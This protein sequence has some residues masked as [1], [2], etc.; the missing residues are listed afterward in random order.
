[1]IRKV[2]IKNYALIE[3]VSVSFSNGFTVITG[4]TGAGKSILLSAL[5]LALGN[6]LENKNLFDSTKKCIVEIEIDIPE[7]FENWFITNDVDYAA[8][9]IIRRE[10]L[11]SGK[12]RLFINDSPINQGDLRLLMDQLISI[13]SQHEAYTLLQPS[14]QLKIL[15]DFSDTL[16]LATEFKVLVQTYRALV[17]KRDKLAQSQSEEEKKW[18]YLS[19]IREELE[20][21]QV[22]QL[23]ID[24]LEQEQQ[25]LAEVD[26]IRSL[27][28]E[29]QFL[30]S[31]DELGILSQLNKQ[32]RL[33]SEL[34]NKSGQFS[35]LYERIQ[36]CFIE[37]KDI[38]T[39]LERSND[40]IVADPNRLDELN[41][42]LSEVYRLQQKHKLTDFNELHDLYTSLCV[43]LSE[44]QPV[45]D[46]L[47]DI[48]IE[49]LALEQQID[50]K[51]DKLLLLRQ[52]GAKI[53][54]TELENV[55]SEL[56]MPS[57]ELC[58]EFNPSELSLKGKH[59]IDLKFRANKGGSLQP[60]KSAISGGELSRL[61]L[62]ME[63]VR[64]KI[65]AIPAQIFDEIDS[66]VSGNVAD[67]IAQLFCKMGES[68][69][70]IVI[71]HLPQVA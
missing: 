42:T 29:S 8:Q 59:E 17:D 13:H 50:E 52:K 36:S 27:L 16:G 57:A 10:L 41:T 35:T 47:K 68:V 23:D 25:T 6:R 44:Y 31:D 66:G 4:E 33:L 9:S 2:Y 71:S 32:V 40:S 14:E 24:S 70:L 12:S 58:F 7:S 53:L 61:S 19:F 64:S 49:L 43:Q 5:Q 65:G 28:S 56:G 67:K 62:A 3:E 15:D 46:Q 55:L 20:R 51:A 37:L 54:T 11:P 63:Y 1:M 26:S 69:Q 21:A 60:L 22:D 34:N 45:E 39:E 30:M 18:D 48:K 38:Y